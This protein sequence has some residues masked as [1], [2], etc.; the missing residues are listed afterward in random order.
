MTSGIYK[1]T[2]KINGKAYIGASTNIE[3]RWSSHRCSGVGVSEVIIKEGIINF[4]FE[5]IE[6]CSFEEFYDKER[7]YIKAYDTQIPNGYNKTPGGEHNFNITGY[8]HVS[9]SKNSSLRQ[10]FKWLY[11]YYDE[12]GKEKSFSSVDLNQLKKKVISKGLPWKVIDIEKARRSDELNISKGVFYTNR[13]TSGFYNVSKVTDEEAAPGYVWAYHYDNHKN[14]R[15]VDLED[16]KKEVLSRGLHWEVLDDEN[17]KISYELNKQNK[18][19]INQRENKTGYYNVSNRA[20]TWIYT[21]RENNKQRNIKR[22]D[23]NELKKEVSSRGL[24]WKIL[25]KKQAVLSNLKNEKL[26]YIRKNTVRNNTGF[27]NVSKIKC[28][29][30]PKGYKYVYSYY[31]NGIQRRISSRNLFKLEEKVKRKGLDWQIVDKNKVK[32]LLNQKTI[33]SY[34]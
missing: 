18:N 14:I 10:G 16:L 9:K 20:N 33:D 26:M 29:R 8:Y 21:Y 6:E 5:I 31:V 3:K 17:A 27:R 13:N 22:V 12:V 23:L 32:E 11:S 7:Y 2:N 25:D 4:T 28:K 15:R 19:I 1:I 30:C 24:K 34:G